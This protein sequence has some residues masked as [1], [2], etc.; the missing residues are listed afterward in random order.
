MQN[1]MMNF[2]LTLT[3]LLKRAGQL[4]GGSEIVS[5]LPDKSLHR[6]TY[7]DF[8]RRASALA[9][10]L[11]QLG[12]KKGE[13]VAT[14]MWNHYA[15]LETYF[16]APCAGSVLHTLNLRLHPDDIAFIV[17]HAQDRFL[18]VDDVLLPLYE[19]FKAQTKFEHVIAV[20]LTKQPVA[21]GYDDYE[22][23]LANAP[24]F[25]PP[26]LNENDAC[27]MCYTS[28]TTGK[29]KGVVY[30]HRSTV[31][32]ALATSTVDYMGIGNRDTLCPVVPMFHV[33]AWGL[34]YS[35]AMMGAKIAFPGPHLDAVN[36]L[37]LMVAENVTVSAGVPTIWMGVLQAVE[38]EPARWKLAPGLRMVCGGAAAPE[39]LIRAMDRY[40]M[41][42][43]HGW[44]MTELS[45]LGALNFIKR[46]LT[47]LTRDEEYAVRAK[48]GVAP[49]FVELRTMAES[50]EAPWDGVAMGELQVRGPWVAA[51]YHELP[52]ESDQW[53]ADGWFRTGDIAIMDE[54]G[55]MKIADRIKDLVK[56][57][58]EWISSVDL[59]NA[60]MA[61]PAVAEAAVIAVPHPRWD[62]R[63][64]AVVVL[65]P[66]A[67]ATPDALRDHLEP[68]FAK[69]WLP[70]DY[71][72]V[73]AIPKTS[74]GKMLKA[75]LRSQYAK[76]FIS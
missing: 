7:R 6:Y 54:H 71:K 44:G 50:G 11:Q 75:T 46:E 43:I 38:K 52:S 2:P 69:F 31:L 28:G 35:A 32:H 63:P 16:A 22:K 9:G 18:I 36:L 58:G 5:R 64:V 48:Q 13:R 76:L 10:A 74:T 49:P 34:P 56:S 73:D 24:A 19:K 40:G 12:I 67:N 21:A 25:D 33:N 42:V 30:S 27:G 39:A 8:Q 59:E 65:K 53:T 57:G 23:L 47:D 60:L 45:P 14:L 51:G 17:N 66:G 41:R 1:T 15:H 3:H 62:E 26:P 68:K 20:P 55:Y 61:H 70:D 4:F 29:P 37:D 72:F